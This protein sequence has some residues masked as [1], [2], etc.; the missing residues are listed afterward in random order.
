MFGCITLP[1]GSCPGGL[2][3][4]PYPHETRRG[5]LLLRTLHPPVEDGDLLVSVE[6]VLTRAGGRPV[7]PGEGSGAYEAAVASLYRA[8][9][10]AAL[11][12]LEGLYLVFLWDRAR[13]RFLLVNNPYQTTTL[14]YHEGPERLLF[15]KTLT[16]IVRNLPAVDVDLRSVKTY[17]ANGFNMSDRTTILGVHKLQP[18]FRLRVEGGRVSLADH[19]ARELEN[20]RRPIDDLEAHL[21][22]YETLYRGGLAEYLNHRRPAELGCLM[23]GGHDTSFAFLEASQVHEKPVHAF[24]ATFP[25]WGFNE[26]PY[27]RAIAE[28]FGGRF[29]PVPFVPAD[30]DYT[31]ALIRALEEPMASSALPIHL[32]M[33]EASNHVDLMLGGDGGDT[34]WGEYYPV[35]EVNRYMRHLP[36]VA[37]KALYAGVR[38]L[39]KISDW[40]RFW[41]LEH[42]LWLFD[43]ADPYRE[44][45]RRLCTYRHFRDDLL[46]R[47]MDPQVYRDNPYAGSIVEVPHGPESLFEDLIASKLYNGFYPYM[48]FYTTKSSEHYGMDLYLPTVH[49]DVIRLITALPHA[50]VNGGTTFHRMTNNKRI[51]RL[52]HKRALARYLDPREIRNLSFDIPWAR[53]LLPRPRI[54]ELLLERLVRRGWF[55]EPTLRSLFREFRAQRHKEHELLEL[56]NHGYRIFTLLSLEIWATEYLDGRMTDS[57][58][59]RIVLEDYL[60]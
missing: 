10:E 23:S 40:E 26:E 14:Y 33:R 13:D 2:P 47:L 9:G 48:S 28:K 8:G 29:H 52:F 16:D 44:F 59:E 30:L 17:L 20:E 6:G 18:T 45:L 41:E 4:P 55:H 5:R 19:W 46:G 37:R 38:G 36:R 56:K 32:V 15:S 22:R 11:E 1:T 49:R 12:D 53:I 25:G 3:S 51:N 50:W 60:A 57:P 58:E 34:L 24:T 7:A 54:I 31:V 39:L 42:V 35:A 21:D 27:S 43:D